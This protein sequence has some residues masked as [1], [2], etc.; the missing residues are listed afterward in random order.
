MAQGAV[1]LEALISGGDDYEILCA[2]PEDRFEAFALAAG[3]AG[4]AVTSIGTI[5]A[6]T[7][8]S[9]VSGCAGQGTCA[10]PPLLEPLLGP[11][12]CK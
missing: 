4:V 12:R 7:A 8:R 11:F 3:Q 9:L 2:I 5:I 6:G 1:G 10:D